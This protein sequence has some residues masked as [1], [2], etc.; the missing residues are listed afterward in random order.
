[1]QL[2]QSHSDNHHIIESKTT[3]VAYFN[4]RMYRTQQR[5]AYYVCKSDPSATFRATSVVR[6]L[7]GNAN[8][9]G[10]YVRSYYS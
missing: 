4:G 7:V 6:W 9:H 2:A 8:A 1:M 5:T 10:D 3:T